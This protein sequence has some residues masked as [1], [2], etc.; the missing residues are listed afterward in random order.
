MDKTEKIVDFKG[1]PSDMGS[2]FESFEEEGE[3]Y[4]F[5][6]GGRR[7]WYKNSVGDWVST[8]ETGFK[9]KLVSM[10]VMP[11]ITKEE[12]QEGKLLSEVD[13]KLLEIESEA[14]VKYAGPV[15]GYKRGMHV[16]CGD[17]VLVTE[18]LNL[19]EPEAGEWPILEEYLKN[20][21]SSEGWV[22]SN[23]GELIFINE[24]DTIPRYSVPEDEG[25]DQRKF[26]FAWLAQWLEAAHLGKPSLG[27]AMVFAG[28]TNC[29]KTFFVDLIK[30]LFG[31]KEAH[32]YQWLLGG[33]FNKE[34]VGTSVLIIDDEVSKTDMKSRKDLGARLKQFVAVPSIRIEGKGADALHLKPLH[35]LIFM[36]NMD[37]DN[38]SVLP[39]PSVD[40]VDADGRSGK[41]MLVKCYKHG[42]P[43]ADGIEG[44]EEGLF[45]CHGEGASSLRALPLE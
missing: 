9:R 24:G 39:P 26:V 38:L 6:P 4:W 34:L 18:E 41:M 20:L 27:Q 15:A 3:L 7:Y 23:K 28:D 45:R 32:P 36:T 43:H 37:E 2:D 35:R 16:I 31:G 33:Q 12:T 5:T 11:M 14:Q 30:E 22:R 1:A 8:I 44:R 25:F 19:I 13:E 21:L 42:F 10:G 17:R 40:L 29:G